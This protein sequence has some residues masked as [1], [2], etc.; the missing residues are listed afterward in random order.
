[1]KILGTRELKLRPPY[2]P[3]AFAA[4]LALVALLGAGGRMDAS[5]QA[6]VQ[7][8]PAR[9]I[10]LVPAVTE[11]LFAIGA[12]TEV[13]GVSSF[14]QYPPEVRNRPRVGALVDPDFERI[15]SL[16]P[17]LVIV[18]N[19][20]DELI[21][22]LTRVHIPVFQYEHRGLDDIMTTMDRLGARIGRAAEAASEVARIRR[23]L[24]D[25][26]RRVAGMPRPR[27]ALLF[28]RELGALRGIF[29]SAGVGFM[30][31]M[32]LLAGG[33]DVFDDI[34]RQSL[35]VTIE[36]LLARAPDVIVEA[37]P[38]A[39]WTPERRAAERA[40][41]QRL[42]TLP[43]V[44]RNRVHILADDVLLVPGP[45]VGIAVRMIADVL[46]PRAR[47]RALAAWYEVPA[48]ER[49]GGFGGA[50][51]P[52]HLRARGAR[53]HTRAEWGVGVPASERAG[54]FGGAEPPEK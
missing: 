10:S 37:H 33:E 15:L 44:K 7:T 8:R 29:A 20:Q 45:R 47:E 21:A 52:A 6:G 54:G 51:P 27:T 50:E 39:G 26:R 2:K 14:D 31:D 49:A 22:R 1:M 30:H 28:G 16:R 35:Q 18:Y 41:W 32:L 42:P 5:P 34:R 23:E 46:H 48:S 24:D 25:V 43:A 40:L 3:G 11:M 38:G 53:E 12:G 19:S 4:G 13:V 9:I 36:T 17:D